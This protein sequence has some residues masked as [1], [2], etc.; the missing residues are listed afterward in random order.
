MANETP[1]EKLRNVLAGTARALANDAEVELSFT[2]DAPGQVG[3]Q[4][5]VPMPGRTLPPEQVAEA[6]GFAD[7]F[8]LRSRLHDSGLHL[9]GSPREAVA[10]AVFDAVE[11]ARVEALG[12]RGYAGIADNLEH[13]LD[14][15]LRFSRPRR[16]F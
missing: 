10:R 11:T 16:A 14:V 6:R 3:K 4:I 5:K 13:A 8:A 12:S 1:T 2:A 15:R 9:K 7:S